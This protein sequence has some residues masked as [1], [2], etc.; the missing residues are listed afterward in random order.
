MNFDSLTI[1]RLNQDASQ[2]KVPKGSSYIYSYP[3]FINYFKNQ[4]TFDEQTLVVGSHLV[5]GWMPRVLTINTNKI[6]QA[7]KVI[8]KARTADNLTDTDLQVLKTTI[9]NSIVGV[10]KL[11]HFINP[12]KYAIWDS[13]VCSYILERKAYTQTN[14]IDN[15]HVYLERIQAL[16]NDEGYKP[17]HEKVG[18]QLP[19]AISKLRSIEMVMFLNS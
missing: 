3:H 8:N 13:K 4:K 15:Y 6:D 18:K 16:V 1:D 7:I 17:I 9:N 12:E 11:L 10:S 19:Y 5:Y 2:L 14:R